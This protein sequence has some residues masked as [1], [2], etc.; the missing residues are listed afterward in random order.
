MA[1]K[2]ALVTDSTCDIP[3]AWI[4][5]YDIAVVP[6]TIIFGDEQ[7]RDG[8][9]LSAEAFYARLAKERNHP[10]TSQPAP[11][12][13]LEAYNR[14]A[15]C[16]SEEILVITISGAMSGTIESARRAGQEASIPVQV[17]DSKNNSM[18]LGW[19]VI[20]AARAREA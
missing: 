17:L 14:A 13:F 20:A 16:G 15:A 4:N 2:V 7:Y 19:Q 11:K 12:A 6:L 8:V 1:Y 10:S 5:Q 18:G 3:T 9:D